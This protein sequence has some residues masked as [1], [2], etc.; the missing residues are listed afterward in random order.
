MMRF[1][2]TAV[3]LADDSFLGLIR[4]RAYEF[5]TSAALPSNCIE[6][7]Q[8]QQSFKHLITQLRYNAVCVAFGRENLAGATFHES[9]ET[10]P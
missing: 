10:Q 4:L 6:F 3:T 9:R 5:G 8:P 7:V 2:S 1:A